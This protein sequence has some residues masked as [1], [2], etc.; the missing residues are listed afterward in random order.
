MGDDHEAHERGLVTVSVLGFRHPGSGSALLNPRPTPQAIAKAYRGSY[1][2]YKRR[3]A[4]PV[5]QGRRAR[6]RYAV[7]D[8][9]LR[10]RWGYAG[11]RASAPL[12]AAATVMPGVRRA[13]DRL[14]RFVPAPDGADARLLDIGCGAGT[15]LKLMSDLGWDVRGIEPDAEAVRKAR[16]A[17]LEVRQGRWRTSTSMSTACSTS[18]RSAT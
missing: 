10:R 16:R 4:R 15:Y 12:A 17:G 7:T 3:R 18:S 6:L 2:P 9:Y 14:V 5:P 13:A 8:A 1:R 11:L